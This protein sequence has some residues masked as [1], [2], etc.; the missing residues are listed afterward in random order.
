M[1]DYRLLV[2]SNNH[3]MGIDAV[4]Q[5]TLLSIEIKPK[6]G[7]TAIS[8]LVDPNRRIK[9][10]QCRYQLLH[11][12]MTQYNPLHLWSCN[13]DKIRGAVQALVDEPRNNFTLWLARH[14][15][16]SNSNNR[17]AA[18]TVERGLPG[19]LMPRWMEGSTTDT[20][21]DVVTAVI[22]HEDSFMQR[23]RS[24]QKLDVI[25]S[26]GAVRIYD[27]L[28]QH[29]LGGSQ[30]DAWELLDTCTADPNQMDGLC[31][32]QPYYCSHLPC[33]PRALV[34]DVGPPSSI[35]LDYLA[36]VDE[37]QSCLSSDSYEESTIER[38][39]RNS[40]LLVEEMT[41]DDCVVLLRLW[42]LSLVMCDLSMF[43][44]IRSLG[45][46]EENRPTPSFNKAAEGMI[47]SH[48]LQSAESPGVLLYHTLGQVIK[49]NYEIKVIDC[50]RKPAKKLES[51]RA[52]EDAVFR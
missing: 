25:D 52:K 18:T 26:D 16:S 47:C 44:R 28:V 6:A 19:D 39:H 37:L 48:T 4:Q 9:Y 45:Q 1:R 11:G 38:I 24:L 3:A 20:F 51:R 29:H 23:I 2:P 27:H 34:S 42:L 7:Y 21:L 14:D 32:I 13:T 10:H 30:K 36:N 40:I 31:T 5:S 12:H 50:D 41:R 17:N 46:T 8:P 49:I 35:L 22:Y 15:D 43:I 33:C